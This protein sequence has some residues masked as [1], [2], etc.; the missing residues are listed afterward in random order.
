MPYDD[1]DPSDPT[2]LVGVALPASPQATLDMAYTFA[3][4]FARAGMDEEAILGLFADPFYAGP[5]RAYRALGDRA[6]RELVREC[7]GIWG[8]APGRVQDAPAGLSDHVH[9]LPWPTSPWA[10][11]GEGPTGTSTSLREGRE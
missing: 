4:E 11:S 7:V 8:R 9:Q 6:V 5:H 3:E 10:S 2:E 1:P